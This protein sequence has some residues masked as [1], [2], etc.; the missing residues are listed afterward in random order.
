L[1]VVFSDIRRFTAISETLAPDEVARFLS[2]YFN[3]LQEVIERHRGTTDKFIGDA[4]MAFWG[5]PRPDVQHAANAVHAVLECHARLQ[6]LNRH[7]KKLGRPEFETTFGMAS[8]PVV[9]GNVGASHRLNYTVL[10][11]TVNIASRCVALA[12]QLGC[13]ILALESVTNAS[14]GDIEWRRL[15]PVRIRGIREP[16]MV[17]EPLAQRGQTSPET[18]AFRDEYHRALDAY[19]SKDFPRALRILEALA[20]HRPEDLSVAYLLQRCEQLKG[21]AA[22]DL[23]TEVLLFR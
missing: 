14:S 17:C 19:L 1:T 8:G 11:N 22:S 9:V 10:G 7:W 15:G 2:D 16:M 3:V 5:A 18:I 23:D 12:R 20:V 21:T 6:D 13:S 4:I